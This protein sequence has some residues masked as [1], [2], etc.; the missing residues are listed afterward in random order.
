[1]IGRLVEMIREKQSNLWK[2]MPIMVLLKIKWDTDGI[3]DDVEQGITSSE[4]EASNHVILQPHDVDDTLPAP[5]SC[6]CD[7]SSSSMYLTAGDQHHASR[8]TTA[9]ACQVI[10]WSP[11]SDYFIKLSECFGKKE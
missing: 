11:W 10:V 6:H 9:T 5:H 8:S 1:M 3:D 4:H 2:F 7:H